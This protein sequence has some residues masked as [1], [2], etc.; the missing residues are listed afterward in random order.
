MTVLGSRITP[1][2]TPT[3]PVYVPGAGYVHWPAEKL[4]SHADWFAR[5]HWPTPE[6]YTWSWRWPFRI[7]NEQRC[8][9][10]GWVWPCEHSRFAQHFSARRVGTH[11]ASRSLADTF[12]AVMLVASAPV[13]V[14]VLVW[15]LFVGG[16]GQ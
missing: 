15:Y 14:V 7:Q 3:G 6:S 4:Q 13:L 1:T 16:G 8:V 10:C 11:R 9:S 12:S 2:T 5:H